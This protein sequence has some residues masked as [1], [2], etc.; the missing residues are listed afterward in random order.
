MAVLVPAGWFRH[1]RRPRPASLPKP[2]LSEVHPVR[3]VRHLWVGGGEEKGRGGRGVLGGSRPW[4]HTHT[5]THTFPPF[6]P[7]RSDRSGSA[8]RA[9]RL[10]ASA[11]DSN[12]ELHPPSPTAR[13]LDTPPSSR[14][15]KTIAGELKSSPS[16]GARDRRSCARPVLPNDDLSS[17][18]L[19]LAYPKHPDAKLHPEAIAS[20]T[21][22]LA[23]VVLFGFGV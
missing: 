6:C 4:A 1:R 2:R 14:P 9:S 17:P 7:I 19:A 22:S 20:V 10:R 5:R 13:D 3:R 16:A 18:P 8:G 23:P 15:A 21:L 12:S 11:T